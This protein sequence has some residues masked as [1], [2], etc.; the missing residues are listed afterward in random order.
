[1]HSGAPG[2]AGLMDGS[3]STLAPL[4]AA[5]LR[6]AQER[7]AFLGDWQLRSARDFDGFFGRAFRRRIADGRGFAVAARGVTGLMTTAGESG[8][9]LPFLITN[10]S[11]PN[12]GGG[13][14]RGGRTDGHQLHRHRYMIRRLAGRRSGDCG[15]VLVFLD[16]LVDSQR[17]VIPLQPKRGLD[18]RRR[19]R[20]R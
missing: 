15:G 20:V 7:E 3:V 16:G 8:I 18:Y 13:D 14:Y 19:R 4:F 2:L 9:T 5:G 11:C 10:F 6:F 12:A 1:M 17:V